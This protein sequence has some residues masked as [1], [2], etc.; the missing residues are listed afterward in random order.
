M[1]FDRMR[2]ARQAQ[3]AEDGDATAVPETTETRMRTAPRL[4][5]DATAPE[6]EEIGDATPGAIGVLAFVA[7]HVSLLLGVCRLCGADI[8]AVMILAP[9][10][11]S[12]L[13]LSLAGAVVT[14]IAWARRHDR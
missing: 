11:G 13:A 1:D 8:S 12:A 7:L 3:L 9:M 10:W 6:P 14:T 4:V 2:R 5:P